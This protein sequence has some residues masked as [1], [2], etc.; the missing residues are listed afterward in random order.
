[1]RHRYHLNPDTHLQGCADKEELLLEA[2]LLALWRAV[3]GV[4]HST[5]VSSA[6]TGSS[7]LQ[8]RQQQQA[9]QT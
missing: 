4:Q 2:Q 5:D 8:Q 6:L 9:Q 7:G 1:L 3:V